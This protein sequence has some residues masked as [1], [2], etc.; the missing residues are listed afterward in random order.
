MHEFIYGCVVHELVRHAGVDVL[1][2]LSFRST[3]LQFN[4]VQIVCLF[5]RVNLY[6]TACVDTL[7]L[8]LSNPTNSLL[9]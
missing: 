9:S 7:D 8:E 3:H 6:R 5:Y 4:V 2:N 1:L